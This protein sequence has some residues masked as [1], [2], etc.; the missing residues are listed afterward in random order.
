MSIDDLLPRL[1]KATKDGDGFKACCPAHEDRTPSLSINQGPDRILLHCHAGCATEAVCGA[2]GITL[3]DLFAEKSN[4]HA[5]GNGSHSGGKAEIVATYDYTDEAGKLLF[6]VVRFAPKDFRQRRPDASSIDG[7]NW[8]TKNTRKVLYRLPKIIGAVKGGLP[9]LIAEGEK[10]VAALERAGFT[11]TC[12]PGGAG[13]WLDE[14]SEALRGADVVLIPDNDEPGRKHAELVA[15]KL[16]GIAKR[17]RVVTLSA[18]K[19]AH[20]FFAAGKD[21]GDLT[22]LIDAAKDSEPPKSFAEVIEDRRF[23]PNIQPP[24]I[25]PVF[26]LQGKPTSTPGNLT[27]LNAQAKAGK[28][29]VIGAAMASIFALDDA[30]TLGFE[31]GNPEGR[32]VLH[33]DTE[34]SREDH[35]HLVART[36]RRAGAN[37]LPLWMRS[38]C[39]TGFNAGQV[40]EAVWLKVREAAQQ[41]GGVHSIFIDGV[42]DLVSDV[43]DA[44]ETNSFVA[45]LH[46]L[47]IEY[48]CP[49]LGVIHFNPGTEKTRG[50]LGSQLERK[51][52]T[53]LRID[54]EGDVSSIWSEKQRRAPILKGT[55]PRFKW[56]DEAGM[57]VSIESGAD[58][59][60]EAK[61]AEA[62]CLRDDVLN[63]RSS[64]RWTELLKEVQNTSGKSATTAK[65][66]LG[67][68]VQL[69]VIEKSF[70]GLW[71]PKA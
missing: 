49:I 4:G 18:G 47:A 65:R 37:S 19:D 29:A 55:G 26:S 32:A 33:F 28:S 11:A 45:R 58:A 5:S 17:V 7:W 30:D 40:Q 43:N 15:G 41:F 62:I 68:W 10:D 56:S 36:I 21:A 8:S 42:A 70:A 38:Y 57:H 63:G 61:R 69:G 16:Q 22:A 6:Q 39:L 12:N 34:Q 2:M 24:A 44:E 71:T 14:Y 59:R 54:K 20:D 9:I 53:N 51:S 46:A 60:M 27:T 23:N 64:M 25:R 48:D 67:E 50:H 52:E 31:S 13:K 35:W 1:Q 66:I 3:A